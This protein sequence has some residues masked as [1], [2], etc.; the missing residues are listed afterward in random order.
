[1]IA[2]SFSLSF[3]ET[4]GNRVAYLFMHLC[5][6]YFISAKPISISHAIVQR[7]G[8]SKRPGVRD[9]NQAMPK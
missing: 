4:S 8:V 9:E 6:R 7:R 3:L 1:M 2:I 5:I